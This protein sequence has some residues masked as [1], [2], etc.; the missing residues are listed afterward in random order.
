MAADK[1][2]AGKHNHSPGGQIW[3]PVAG[4]FILLVVFVWLIEFLDLPNILLGTPPTPFNWGEAFLE[5]ALVAVIGL[6]VMVRLRRDQAQRQRTEETLRQA[7]REWENIFQAISHPTVILDPQRRV[8]KANQ[9]LVKATGRPAQDLVGLK[10]YQIFHGPTNGEPPLGCPFEELLTAGRLETV[11]MKMEALGGT[12]LVSCTPVLDDAGRL[13]RVIHIAT[14]I[15]GRVR[16]EEEVKR[17]TARL[18]TLRTVGL[19][20]AA[21]LDLETLLHSIV[22]R[23]IELLDGTAGGLYLYRPERDVLEWATIV[24][25]DLPPL[26]TVLHRGEG[27]SGKVW[28]TGQPLIV[29]DYRTWEGRAAI[30]AERRWT[31]VVGV[32]VRWGDEFLGVLNVL[33]EP[34]RTFAPAD[35]DLLS[36]FAVQAAIA[37]R[38]AR[39][40]AAEEQARR[41]AEALAQATAALTSTLDL[42]PLLENLLTAAVQVIPAAEKG[43]ILLLDE[44][45]GELCVRATAGY[46]D[47]R[48]RTIRFPAGTGYAFQAVREGQPLLITDTQAAAYRYGEI[49]EVRSIQSAVVAPLRYRDRIIGA[50]SLDNASRPAAFTEA[51]RGLLLAFADQAAVAV[52]NARLYQQ[53]QH[54]LYSLTEL[55]R[56]SQAI[57]SSLEAGEILQQIISLAG[58]VVNSDYTSV[59]LL[60]E[61]GEP[62]LGAEDL[63]GVPSIMRRIRPGG[64]TRHV[65]AT[66]QPFL[67]DEVAPDGTIHPPQPFLANP[68][69]VAAGIRSF[70]AVPIRAKEHTLGVLF[71]HSRQPR[72][73]H[74]Q[75]DLLTTFANQAAV[76]L[77]NAHLYELVRQELAERKRAE[78]ALQFEREQL[79]SIFDSIEEIIYVTDPYTYEIIYANQALRRAFHQD[80]IGGICYREFQGFDSPCPFCTNEIILR[81]RYQPYRW[82]HHNPR[83]D[84]DYAITDRIIKWPDGRDVRFELAID[85]T[86]LKRAEKQLRQQERLAAVGQLAAGIAHDFNNILTGMIGFAQLL[87]MRPDVPESAKAD[88]GRIVQEG[89][90]AAHLIRQILDF[91]RKSIRM[92]QPLDLAAFLEEAGRFLRRTIPERTSIVLDILPGAYPVLADPTQLQQVLTNL[93]INA[94]DAMPAGGELRLSLSRLTLLPDMTA[95]VSDM[96]PGAWAVLSVGDTGT[97]MPPEV[98]NHLFEPFFTTKEVG[99][100]TGLGLAQVYGIVRQHDGFIR[101]ESQVGQGSTFYIYL[102]LTSA[103]GVQTTPETPPSPIPGGRGETILLVE[104]EPLVL[105]ALRAMLEQLGYRVLTATNGQ[106]ALAVYSQH[107]REIALVLADLVM[108]VMDGGALFRALQAQDPH[109]RLVVTTGYPLGEEYQHLLAQGIAGW[110]QK[111]PDQAQLARVLRLALGQEHEKS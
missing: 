29:D 103:E 50:I 100:G 19:E 66:G 73:F 7:S 68:D 25:C 111:P 83:L 54:Q 30:Y 92:P 1:S 5:T 26:G 94:H 3:L 4:L 101:A 93:A 64:V 10:C 84:R 80:L 79:L 69:I 40:L 58:S 48:V 82:E 90:R 18:E 86:E 16:A 75:L 60:D 62:V 107:R 47:P 59:V 102:P 85:I 98:M 91:G 78:K 72:A 110:L 14:D 37:I 24:G 89:R 53:A 65:L 67:A 22:A 87:Q 108:P 104:D 8:L 36:L 44:L 109:I 46:Q 43:S 21:Q 32:P 23:A 9:A 70:A 6:L 57:A 63:R 38:N 77:E 2:R 41:R 35:A 13:E 76:A 51:D 55:N 17:Y 106:E 31:A 42:E 95:P 27:L 52:E 71:V 45:T 97:G 11:E 12:F 33:A 96:P 99:R 34:P 105:A 49:A 28:L 20:L 88:L 15:T 39:I 74:G 81:Q 56:A 61:T